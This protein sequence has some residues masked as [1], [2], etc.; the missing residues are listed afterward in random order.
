MSVICGIDPG[1]KG[2]IAIFDNDIPIFCCVMPILEIKKKTGKI[3]KR[4]D[5]KEV[6]KILK[7]YK[8]EMIITEQV[9]AFKGQGGVGNFS[10]GQNFGTLLGIFDALDI[11]YEEVSPIRWK[12]TLFGENNT[13]GKNPGIELCQQKYPQINLLA[14][15]RS[16]I[17]H[18]GKSDALCLATYYLIKDE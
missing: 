9:H 8:V 17:P 13:E 11:P 15:P 7:L 12:K 1:F 5:A 10:F 14:T 4:I 16:K 3:K 18:D 6:C 2:G